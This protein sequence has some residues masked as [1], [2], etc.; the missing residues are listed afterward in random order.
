MP[1]NFVQLGDGVDR[2]GKAGPGRKRQRLFIQ[3]DGFRIGA[4]LRQPVGPGEPAL[5]VVRILLRH[6]LPAGGGFLRLAFFFQNHAQIQ[7]RM[8]AFAQ[9]VH[10]F[11]IF[12]G[13]GTSAVVDQQIQQPEVRPALAGM[14]GDEVLIE[15]DGS[16]MVDVVPVREDA[17]FR[18][19]QR[20][21]GGFVIFG[22][23]LQRLAGQR[24][25]QFPVFPGALAVQLRQKKRGPGLRVRLQTFVL[26]K[27]LFGFEFLPGQ[28]TLIPEHV[29]DALHPL[30][31]RHGKQRV[32]RGAQQNGKLG[33]Q[34]NIR[35]GHAV[36]PFGYGLRADSETLGQLFL[37]HAFGKAKGLD[38]SAEI[39][40]THKETSVIQDGCSVRA[41]A[42]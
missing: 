21:V 2:V 15:R 5:P 40:G 11:Q 13:F 33:Q 29:V 3:G 4:A 35:Q 41:R 27:A 6:A 26:Q 32:D 8:I 12:P 25:G 42:P 1:L 18:L 34:L 28:K 22:Q 14:P 16:V 20:R 38:P 30:V 39:K 24:R 31:V 36:F 37:R 7:I 19:E 10:F 23:Q 17:A 9:P